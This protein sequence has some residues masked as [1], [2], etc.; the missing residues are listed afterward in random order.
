MNG[1]ERTF[2][3]SFLIFC[4]VVSAYVEHTKGITQLGNAISFLGGLATLIPAF[5]QA[6][7]NRE[8]AVVINMPTDPQLKDLDEGLEVA[9]KEAFMVFK[10]F[11][12]LLFLGG[13]LLICVGFLISI[14]TSPGTSS[15]PPDTS[16]DTASIA[17]PVGAG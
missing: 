2:I 1:R 11:D 10:T 13:L 3:F 6:R 5:G 9:R 8:F 12:Y 4:I 7:K 14:I 16:P 17:Q 15:T